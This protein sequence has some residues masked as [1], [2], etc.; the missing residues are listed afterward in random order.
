MLI[1]MCYTKLTTPEFCYCCSPA[2]R[3][4]AAAGAGGSCSAV[5]RPLQP[6]RW[7]RLKCLPVKT[8]SEMA[9]YSVQAAQPIFHSV[10][11][12]KCQCKSQHGGCAATLAA[13]LQRGGRLQGQLQHLSGFALGKLAW[14]G[15]DEHG[16]F[17]AYSYLGV[18][19]FPAIALKCESPENAKQLHVL[20]PF[21]CCL[22]RA[23]SFCSRSFLFPAS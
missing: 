23:D 2:G 19:P 6:L 14:A 8:D 17:S 9:E 13:A 18:L 15:H 21:S 12:A 7:P 3:A 22:A 1:Q 4:Q 11:S 10:R 5:G 20:T 16:F